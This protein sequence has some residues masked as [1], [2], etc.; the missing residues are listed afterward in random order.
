MKAIDYSLNRWSALIHYCEDG[1]VPID[2]NLIENQMRPCALGHKNW[3]FA[4]S[5]RGGQRASAVMS[6][7]QSTK[8]NGYEPY[9]YLSDTQNR[10]PIKKQPDR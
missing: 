3:L 4:G 10:L 1:A 8:L 7:I 2:N 6:L 9:V 5:L